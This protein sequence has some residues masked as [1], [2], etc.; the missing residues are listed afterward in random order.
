MFKTDSFSF[1]LLPPWPKLRFVA[2]FLWK[3]IPSLMNPHLKYR[4]TVTVILAFLSI[5]RPWSKLEDNI[6]IDFE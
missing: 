1:I 3:L 2:P 5:L 6:K 4:P